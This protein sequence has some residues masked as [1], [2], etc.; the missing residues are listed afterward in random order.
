MDH[1]QAAFTAHIIMITSSH[2]SPRAC[3]AYKPANLSTPTA[4][5]LHLVESAF[6]PD[7]ILI[8]KTTLVIVAVSCALLTLR[9]VNKWLTSQNIKSQQSALPNPQRALLGLPQKPVPVTPASEGLRQRKVPMMPPPAAQRSP[10]TPASLA[11]T[12]LNKPTGAQAWPSLG[13]HHAWACTHHAWACTTPGHAPTTPGHAPRPMHQ[14]D[15]AHHTEA[16]G[17]HQTQPPP[18]LIG[19]PERCC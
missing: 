2:Q 1:H 14:C 8:A 10:M 4:H 9:A 15:A 19:A 18:N 6:T 7:T 12:G 3:I 16:S 17:M 13:M 11:R 5:R